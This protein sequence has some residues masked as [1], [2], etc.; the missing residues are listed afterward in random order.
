MIQ[1]VVVDK[2]FFKFPYLTLKVRSLLKGQIHCGCVSH[3]L[4]Y[5]DDDCELVNVND[6]Y[7]FWYRY[8]YLLITSIYLFFFPGWMLASFG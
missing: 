4:S 3:E 5:S 2:N 1:D 6:F 8:M 7:T